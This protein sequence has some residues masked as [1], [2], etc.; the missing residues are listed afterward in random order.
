MTTYKTLTQA[1]I[2]KI[3]SDL[4]LYGEESCEFQ[5]FT[6]KIV[7][8][9]DPENPFED[10][11]QV[12]TFGI[13]FPR[14]IRCIQQYGEECDFNVDEFLQ[15]RYGE[16]KQSWDD[17]QFENQY[18]WLPVYKYDHSG[19]CYNTT[20]FS[21]PWDS[22]LV[23][24]AYVRKS[25]VLREGLYGAKKNQ[26]ASVRQEA[27]EKYLKAQVQLLSDWASGNVYGY[28]VEDSDGNTTDS[29]YGYFGDDGR[30]CAVDEM[31]ANLD[32]EITV[33]E[34]S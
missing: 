19:V 32:A 22:G 13:T 29:C 5:G 7:R 26:P 10:W 1:D 14:D 31:L 3:K 28:Q 21:C 9:D 11:D 33:D 23:G 27:G 8:D 18:Y 12:D 30:I 25:A 20:G 24:I 2:D 17:T 6:L 4:G 15:H 16:E 34:A